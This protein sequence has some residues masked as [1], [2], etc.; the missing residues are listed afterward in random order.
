MPLLVQ[1]IQVRS[2]DSDELAD[3]EQEGPR[4]TTRLAIEKV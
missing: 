3:P 1:A 4:A 2:P